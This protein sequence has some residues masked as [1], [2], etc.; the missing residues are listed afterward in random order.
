[1]TSRQ[2][3]NL[4]SG[5]ALVFAATIPYIAV[6]KS[7]S[8]FWIEFNTGRHAIPLMISLSIFLSVLGSQLFQFYKLDVG[9]RLLKGS[10]VLALIATSVFSMS[11]SFN[12]RLEN[13]N[14]IEKISNSLKDANFKPSP[15][16]VNIYL[17]DQ[18][19]INLNAR[20]S[21]LMMFRLTHD[22]KTYTSIHGDST[23]FLDAMP[24][25]N[26]PLLLGY[27]IYPGEHNCITTVELVS[28][29]SSKDSKLIGFEV[30]EESDT[31]R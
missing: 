18:P 19:N 1:L 5:C 17:S 7:T 2:R 8:L 21:A 6:G 14:L 9:H 20:D 25:S 30:V 16:L 23:K 11:K 4:L 22:L 15:G 13:Q 12:I 24:P 27:P 3:S 28:Q 26:S 31:C 10:V 29:F